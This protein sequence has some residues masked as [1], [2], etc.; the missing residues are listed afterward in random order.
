MSVIV[1]LCTNNWRNG[2][3]TGHVSAVQVGDSIDLQ[4]GE[5]G[6]EPRYSITDEGLKISHKTF[7][8]RSKRDWYGNWCWTGVSMD[9]QIAVSLLNYL[10][11]DERWHCEGGVC[12]LTDAYTDGKVTQE[13]LDTSYARHF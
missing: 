5:I 8:I 11:K 13:I 6:S 10:S 7:P 2:E 1:S 4:W 12:D 3:D 9:E